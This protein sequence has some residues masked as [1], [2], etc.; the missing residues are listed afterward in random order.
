MTYPGAH[1]RGID[2]AAIL[3]GTI[4][5]LFW[6]ET[7][8]DGTP[9]DDAE[10]A[11][12]TVAYLS[13]RVNAFASALDRAPITS[14]LTRAHLTEAQIGHDLWLTARGHGTGFW[15]RG[16]GAL[17]DALTRLAV[18]HGP[19]ADVYVD[20]GL[21][22]ADHAAALGAAIQSALWIEGE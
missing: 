10:L 12:S 13:E 14:E 20:D 8:D 9:L 18:E 15:D 19:R 11:P 17:G 6:S 2:R 1:H 5:A 21:I 3:R 16:L 4:E 7:D 22:Y